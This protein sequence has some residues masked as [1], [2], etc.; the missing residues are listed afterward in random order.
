MRTKPIWYPYIQSNLRDPIHLPRQMLRSQSANFRN[1]QQMVAGRFL[2]LTLLAHVRALIVFILL[3]QATFSLNRSPLLATGLRTV[4]AAAEEPFSLFSHDNLRLSQRIS[5]FNVNVHKSV[6]LSLNH[7][8]PNGATRGLWFLYLMLER[9]FSRPPPAVQKLPD[10]EMMF[11]R[12]HFLLKSTPRCHQLWTFVAVKY[13]MFSPSFFSV[14]SMKAR[15]E[16]HGFFI[17]HIY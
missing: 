3:S 2:S 12:I 5:T 6:F 15:M 17:G 1:I 8:T 11:T 13:L 16:Q 9:R 10:D 7:D 14:P 4:D